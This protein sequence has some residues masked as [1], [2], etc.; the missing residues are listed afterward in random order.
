MDADLPDS[1]ASV[2]EQA[3]SLIEGIDA[4]MK[5]VLE[6]LNRWFAS[7]EGRKFPIEASAEEIERIREVIQRSGCKLFFKEHQVGIHLV[8]RVRAKHFSIQLRTQNDGSKQ[9][10]VY[11]AA[12][13]PPMALKIPKRS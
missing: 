5:P 4:I 10:V 3:D 11:A 2:Q 13:F 7:L 9:K 1:L 6:R 8:T 12:P